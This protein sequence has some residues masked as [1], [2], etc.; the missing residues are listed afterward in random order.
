MTKLTKTAGI[1]AIVCYSVSAMV[2]AGPDTNPALDVVFPLGTVALGLFLVSS[3]L[4]GVARECEAAAA[5]APEN[6]PK[7]KETSTTDHGTKLVLSISPNIK[8]EAA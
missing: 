6:S 1:I 8:P 2:F 4:E 7:W 3:L 5:P